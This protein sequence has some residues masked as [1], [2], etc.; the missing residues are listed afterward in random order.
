MT[1]NRK[2]TA[3]TKLIEN[4]A[5]QLIVS[6]LILSGFLYILRDF[7]FSLFSYIEPITL[8]LW[9]TVIVVFA[10][11]I[12]CYLA[13]YFIKKKH[14]SSLVLFS[15]PS[16]AR[17]KSNEKEIKFEHGGLK[18]IAYI[19]KLQLI[20]D[21]Y[22]WLTGPFCPDCAC[23]LKWKGKVQKSWHCERCNKNFKAFKKSA[24]DDREFAEDIV[25]AEVFRKK[26]FQD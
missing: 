20:P 25:Y 14:N 8:Q 22:V 26:K 13:N 18:W 15:F 6:L 7:I 19:P 16:R 12:L 23:E 21:E 24:R 4:F 3:F 9:I 10:I 5:V 11:I 17:N 2:S 1:K